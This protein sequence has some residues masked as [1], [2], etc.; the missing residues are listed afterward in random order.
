MSKSFTCLQDP[1]VHRNVRFYA[2]S[3]HEPITIVVGEEKFT[4]IQMSEMVRDFPKSNSASF[5]VQFNN[6]FGLRFNKATNTRTGLQRLDR[7]IEERIASIEREDYRVFV[8]IVVLDGSASISNGVLRVKHAQI[9]CAFGDG[10]APILEED[11]T[12]ELAAN[13]DVILS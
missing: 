13:G 10:D 8:G 2:S 6:G 3:S 4:S 7:R 11:C 1:K 12:F 9:M 5:V